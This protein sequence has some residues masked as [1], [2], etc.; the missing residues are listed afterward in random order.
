MFYID[1][2]EDFLCALHYNS[3]SAVSSGGG[4]AFNPVFSPQGAPAFG[5]NNPF[6]G[7]G[8][9]PAAQTQVDQEWDLF[10]ADRAGQAGQKQ[11]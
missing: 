10:F 3:L 4:P 8:A 11:Q 2:N 9:P 1:E 5:T 7:G 6:S